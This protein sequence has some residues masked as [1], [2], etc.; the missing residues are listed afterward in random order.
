MNSRMKSQLV[1]LEKKSPPRAPESS[2]VDTASN[3]IHV[4]GLPKKDID[5]N[6][7]FKD[8]GTIESIKFVG[9]KSKRGNK[10]S[11]LCRFATIEEA[12]KALNKNGQLIMNH[13]INIWC[14]KETKEGRFSLHVKNFSAK[15]TAATLKN[16]FLQCGPIA[17]IKIPQQPKTNHMFGFVDFLT[18]KGLENALNLQGLTI[19]GNKVQLSKSH[20]SELLK[21][22]NRPIRK[23]SKINK[24]LL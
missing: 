15:V 18:S 5:L 21:G 6:D 3:T 24:L 19:K 1:E 20:R 17:N 14:V 2:I 9:Q 10:F 23:I 11:A 8:C 16:C 7:F 12:K 4:Q 13:K 22:P